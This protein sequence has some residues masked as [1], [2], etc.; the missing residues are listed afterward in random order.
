MEQTDA[1]D[2][3]PFAPPDANLLGD[4][5]AEYVAA[6]AVAGFRRS[7][8]IIGA[9]I[10]CIVANSVIALAQNLW[11]LVE[12]ASAPEV[13]RAPPLFLFTV[14]SFGSTGCGLASALSLHR[15]RRMLLLR[16]ESTAPSFGAGV[17]H[18]R[19]FWKFFFI[20]IACELATAILGGL[21]IDVTAP[22]SE[23]P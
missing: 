2:E 8:S 14:L 4:D 16:T 1:P 6:G 21:G 3:N 13:F 22:Y 5:L 9:A 11:Q 18:Y 23:L 12:F 17:L 15:F 19:N 10:F 20:S 7:T